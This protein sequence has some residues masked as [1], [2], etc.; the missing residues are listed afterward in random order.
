MADWRKLAKNLLLADNK[1]DEQEVRALRKELYADGKIERKELEF[2]VELRDALKTPSPVFDRFFFKAV[3]DG[4]LGN[5]IISA[6][7]T[8]WLRSM[9]FADKKVDADE[10]RLMKD[11]KKAAT[12]VDKGFDALYAEVVG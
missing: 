5:G 2:L 12:K 7:E 6:S 9:I 1:I 8:R 10:K 11:L 3:K 4:I